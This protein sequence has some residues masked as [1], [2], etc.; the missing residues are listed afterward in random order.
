MQNKQF[1]TLAA[2][3]CG[4]TSDA[5][6]ENSSFRVGGGGGIINKAGYR[7]GDKTC[8]KYT[9]PHRAVFARTMP[10]QKGVN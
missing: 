6:W 5:E 8:H 10:T 9:D 7:N 3:V 4:I 1:V 2:F